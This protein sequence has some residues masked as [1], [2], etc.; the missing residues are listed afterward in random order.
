ME[1]I[2]PVAAGT[3]IRMKSTL[4]IP[5]SWATRPGVAI[6]LIGFVIRNEFAAR[7]IPWSAEV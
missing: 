4:S 6:W 7:R 1:V 5:W 3:S 2:G